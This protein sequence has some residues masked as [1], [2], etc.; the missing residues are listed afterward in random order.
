MMTTMGYTCRFFIFTGPTYANNGNRYECV[1]KLAR[2][3]KM[4]RF[5]TASNIIQQ[6]LLVL[7]VIRLLH[8]KILAGMN[9]VIL[10]LIVQLKIKTLQKPLM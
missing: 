6:M 3:H 8:G 5:V 2:F 9:K 7:I 1:L 4:S 10:F